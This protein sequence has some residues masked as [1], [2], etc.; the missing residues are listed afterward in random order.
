M[1]ALRATRTVS[2]ATS[3][4]LGPFA[5]VFVFVLAVVVFLFGL[6]MT[7]FLVFLLLGRGFRTTIGGRSALREDGRSERQR[8]QQGQ[9][10]STMER[11]F[12]TRD[13]LLSI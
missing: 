7:F 4:T 1:P 12:H 11:N 9:A 8:R 10:G 13:S 3:A 2:L 5:A 6:A